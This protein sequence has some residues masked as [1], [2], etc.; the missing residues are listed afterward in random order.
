MRTVIDLAKGVLNLIYCFIKLMPTKDRVVIIS[1]QA[2]EPTEDISLLADCLAKKGCNVVC[3]CRTLGGGVGGKIAYI[4]HMFRQ[5]YYLATSKV[6]VLDSYCI[7]ASVLHHKKSLTIIQMWHALGSLKRF[8]RSITGAEEGSS[9]ELADAMKMHH[10]YNYILTS[11]EACLANF[12]EAFGY[13]NNLDVMKVMSLPRVDK[14][15]DRDYAEKTVGRIYAKYPE[16]KERKLVVYA[17][18]FRKGRDISAEIEALSKEF[19]GDEYVF[20]LKKHPLMKESC[21]N[22]LMDETFTTKEMLYAADYIICD[23]SAIVY[24]AAILEKPLFFYT[25]DYESYGVDRNFYIDYMKEMPGIKSADPKAI[26]ESVKNDNYDISE[27]RAFGKKYVERQTGCTEALA[28]L[29]ISLL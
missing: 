17:P 25:F 8:G 27:V 14:L 19:A 11:S 20:C 1:R 15:T 5:M 23:Y 6:A 2:D 3:L 26:Y 22:V 16:F 28:E 21:E 7:C 4:P 18:T 9:K 29:V 12:A 13:Q 10:G 24:E